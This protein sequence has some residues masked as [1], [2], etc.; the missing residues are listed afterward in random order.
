MA[1]KKNKCVCHECEIYFDVVVTGSLTSTGATRMLPQLC[2]F[3]GDSI[4]LEDERPFLK[5]FDEY[6]DFDDDKYY[7]EDEDEIDDD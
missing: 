7:T 6:D 4:Q 5:D 2:P 3:C 1:K